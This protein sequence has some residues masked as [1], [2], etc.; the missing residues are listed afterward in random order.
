MT[1]FSAVIANVWALVFRN[2]KFNG[3]NLVISQVAVILPYLIQAPRFFTRQITLGQ[4]TQSSD[5]FGQVMISNLAQRGIVLQTLQKYSSLS[6]QK[7]RLK[8]A[9]FVSGQQA[10]DVNFLFNKWIEEDEKESVSKCEM[11][12]EVEE[13]IML[14]QHYCVAWG[15]RGDEL[16]GE[17]VFGRAW[18][19]LPVQVADIG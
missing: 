15:W 6:A 16:E 2:L 13:W 9:G 8:Q 5:A 11:L 14:A 10:A 3:T 7:L 18:S 1:R 19:D 4:F 17:D 12:D